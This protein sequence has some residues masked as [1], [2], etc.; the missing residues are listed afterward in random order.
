M[1]GRGGCLVQ[2]GCMVVWE[3]CMVPGGVHSP[4]G[5]S[6]W[7]RG[8]MVPEEGCMVQ[9]VCAWSWGCAWLGG[10]WSKGVHGPRGVH[11]LGRCMVGGGGLVEIPWTA[12]AAGG[13]HPTGMHSCFL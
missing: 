12:N 6:V 2:G 8:C 5:G 11:G 13:M 9:G 4:E 1:H 3:G 7:S 10:V